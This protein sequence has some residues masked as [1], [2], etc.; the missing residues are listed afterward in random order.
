MIR[1]QLYVLMTSPR[2]SS[3]VNLAE[4][5]ICVAVAVNQ[6]QSMF[7]VDV[8]ERVTVQSN[9][10]K[11]IGKNMGTNS[12][13]KNNTGFVYQF[14]LV[15]EHEFSHVLVFFDVFQLLQIYSF[16]FYFC[17]VFLLRVFT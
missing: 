6:T 17:F 10:K 8:G 4:W 3:R 13:V 14:K 15:L 12:F 5:L 2:L 11:L 9:V 1:N 16:A 7:V